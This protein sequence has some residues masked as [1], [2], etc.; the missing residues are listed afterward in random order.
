MKLLTW[1]A[2]TALVLSVGAQSIGLAQEINHPKSHLPNHIA[3]KITNVRLRALVAE[4]EINAE[5]DDQFGSG[6]FQGLDRSGCNVNVGN[7]TYTS[8]GANIDKDVVIVGDVIN[9]CQ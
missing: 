1:L 6:G 8:P 3:N 9:Y 2:S 5:L 4:E 7:T